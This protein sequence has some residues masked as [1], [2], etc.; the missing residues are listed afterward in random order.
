MITIIVTFVPWL[1][2]TQYPV[3]ISEAKKILRKNGCFLDEDR[4]RHEWWFSSIT[5]NHFPLP[6]HGT[7]DIPLGTLKS[8]SELSGVKF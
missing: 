4:K 7:Q 2:K 3:K 1:I 8:I 5:G 6:R